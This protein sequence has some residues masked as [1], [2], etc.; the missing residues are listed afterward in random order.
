MDVIIEAEIGSALGDE[1]LVEYVSG[2][3]AEAPDEKESSDSVRDFLSSV[4][5][6]EGEATKATGKL[7]AALRAAG[8][9]TA[10]DGSPTTVDEPTGKVRCFQRLS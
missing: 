3:L 9:G 1:S 2:M 10:S 4:G 7:F 5:L 6:D 8:F